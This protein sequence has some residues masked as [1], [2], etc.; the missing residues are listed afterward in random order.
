M[1]LGLEVGGGKYLGLCELVGPLIVLGYWGEG[2][3]GEGFQGRERL[4]RT[5][6]YSWAHARALK[7]A[8]ARVGS[9]AL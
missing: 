9:W 5:V 6:L 8:S 1:K 3:G 4:M 7:R 2:R